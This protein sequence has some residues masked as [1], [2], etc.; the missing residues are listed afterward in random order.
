M[1]NWPFILV[2]SISIFCSACNADELPPPIAPEKCD[3]IPATYESNVQAIIAQ[4][5][6]YSGACHLGEYDSYGKLSSIVRNGRF[7]ERV[8]LLRTDPI[9]G[10]PPNNAPAGRPTDLTQEQLDILECWIS[11]NHPER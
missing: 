10:M 3:Q 4:S 7:A 6:T 9:L 2:T 11:N 1:K 5:C 8:F